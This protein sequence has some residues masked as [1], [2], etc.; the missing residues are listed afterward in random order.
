MCFR[1][2]GNF[3]DQFIINFLLTLQVEEFRKS[4]NTWRRMNKSG[5]IV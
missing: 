1:S 5:P 4:V 3:D 2:G